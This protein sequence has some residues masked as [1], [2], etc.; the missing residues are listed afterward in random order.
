MLTMRPQEIPGYRFQESVGKM[1]GRRQNC[2]K[3]ETIDSA[4]QNREVKTY[5]LESAK[6]VSS[7]S[8]SPLDHGVGPRRHFKLGLTA[9]RG[10]LA[11]SMRSH[12]VGSINSI[13]CLEIISRH[14]IRILNI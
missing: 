8:R 6:S 11:Q 10:G 4:D 3:N 14:D 1:V 7:L 2:E 9:C 13:E 5:P 12:F